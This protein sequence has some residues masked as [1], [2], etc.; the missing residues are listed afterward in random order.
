MLTLFC[1]HQH[2]GLKPFQAG[3]AK[4]TT[5]AKEERSEEGDSPKPVRRR[6]Q[7]AGEHRPGLRHP[8]AEASSEV[9]ALGSAG[10]SAGPGH[11][12]LHGLS[13]PASC[14]GWAFP[15]RPMPSWL[16]VTEPIQSIQAKEGVRWMLSRNSRG[17]AQPN[18]TVGC[19]SEDGSSG[20]PL[21]LLL[22]PRRGQLRACPRDGGG[23][24]ILGGYRPPTSASFSGGTR[25]SSLGSGVDPWV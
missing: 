15:L 8:G 10:D 16:Q 5:E 6:H 20:T 12:P 23:W 9:R 14:E 4:A 19:R 25:R 24:C 21:C 3:R 13:A 7:A 18:R 11:E 17:R 1:D 2:F 22:P